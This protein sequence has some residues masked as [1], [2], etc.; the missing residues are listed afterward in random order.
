MNGSGLES[1]C[2]RTRIGV[3]C[4]TKLSGT[5]RWK[6][7]VETGRDTVTVQPRLSLVDMVASARGEHL[8]AHSAITEGFSAGERNSVFAGNARRLYRLGLGLDGCYRPLQ[9]TT[10]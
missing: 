3:G 5:S 1:M 8:N 9:A 2:W 10:F 6:R 4:S 7:R